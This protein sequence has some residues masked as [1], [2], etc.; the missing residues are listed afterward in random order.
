MP[1]EPDE[2]AQ[3]LGHFTRRLLFCERRWRSFKGIRSNSSICMRAKSPPPS[4]LTGVALL[5][6]TAE[7][8]SRLA[9][10]LTSIK[11]ICHLF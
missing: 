8:R 10:M 6:I 2:L 3:H 11:R 4:S 9:S 7:K 5:F 1:Y